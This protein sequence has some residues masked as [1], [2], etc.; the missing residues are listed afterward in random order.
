[1][2]LTNFFSKRLP[3]VLL[4]FCV[5][6][7]VSCKKDKSPENLITYTKQSTGVTWE[8]EKV[9]AIIVNDSLVLRGNNKD[10]SSIAI[11]VANSYSGIYTVD[12]ANF[13]SLIIINDDGSKDNSSNYLSIEGSVTIDNNDTKN[14]RVKGYFNIQAVKASAI[15]SKE[16]I[17][18]TFTAKYTQY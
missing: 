6:L 4:F 2:Y 14:K 15:T 5:T 11:V 3:V 7:L 13:Q 8:S 9:T 10:G 17:N 1:M 18:G 12:M 16:N